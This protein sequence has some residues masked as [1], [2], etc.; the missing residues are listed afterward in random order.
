[1]NNLF[2]WIPKTGGTS[3]YNSLSTKINMQIYIDNYYT[4]NNTGNV[5]FGHAD[6]GCLLSNQIITK[7]Y[8][9]NSNKFTVVRNPYSRFV[10]LYNDFKKS[11]RINGNT[12]LKEFANVI[13]HFTRKPGLFNVMDYSQAASQVSWLLPGVEVYRLE[14]IT[15]LNRDFNLK[16]SHENRTTFDDWLNYYCQE[17]LKMVTDIYYDDFALLNYD[18]I[19]YAN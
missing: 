1:M 19:E 3:I 17:T 9:Q 7:E 6:V 12:T 4:F 15:K 10:S 18:I 14:N 16:I 5:T 8:W 13:S 2:I 11:K